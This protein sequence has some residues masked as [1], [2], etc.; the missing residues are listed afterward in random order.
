MIEI[1]FTALKF[2]K[3]IKLNIY[4]RN[5]NTFVNVISVRN[6]ST[7]PRQANILPPI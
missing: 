7:V 4:F 2:F 1:C 6:Y 3:Q 5:V